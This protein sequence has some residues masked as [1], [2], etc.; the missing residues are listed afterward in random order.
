M[1]SPLSALVRR[2]FQ[3]RSLGYQ[4]LFEAVRCGARMREPPYVLGGL[5]VLLGYVW[6]WLRRDPPLMPMPAVRFL[7][8][9]QRGK[10]ARGLAGIVPPRR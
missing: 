7:H 1:G 8:S 5:G 10:L 2:G 4:G 6:S 3:D 9:E